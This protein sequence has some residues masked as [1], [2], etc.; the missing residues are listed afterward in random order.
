MQNLLVAAIVLYACWTVL[1]RYLSPALMARLLNL[2]AR[3]CA[4]LGWRS[5]ARRLTAA[6][7]APQASSAC[8]SCSSCAKP[9]GDTDKSGNSVQK[10]P[11]E[12]L[13]RSL[14]R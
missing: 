11:L 1:K 4:R 6:T 5:M 2:L 14:R 13:R 8:G 9:P 3:L 10:I 12:S 7:P